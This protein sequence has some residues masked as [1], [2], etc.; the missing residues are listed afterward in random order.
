MH[1]AIDRRS[2]QEAVDLSLGRLQTGYIDLYQI[3]WPDR[4]V[5]CFGQGAYDPTQERATLPMQE[6]LEALSAVVK[7]GKSS[8]RDPQPLPQPGAVMSAMLRSRCGKRLQAK[9]CNTGI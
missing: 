2:V 3:H 1:A 4:Y 6:Q 9:A 8:R 5:P 7:A